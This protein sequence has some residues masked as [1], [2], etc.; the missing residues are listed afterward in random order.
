MAV[1]TVPPVLA[2]KDRHC[3]QLQHAIEVNNRFPSGNFTGIGEG[4]GVPWQEEM[5]D[6]ELQEL[7]FK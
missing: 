7:R 5:V 1:Q 3:M 6:V 4:M 2:A